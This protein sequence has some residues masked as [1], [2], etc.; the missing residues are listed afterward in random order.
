MWNEK[1][2]QERTAVSVMYTPWHEFNE[3]T[4]TYEESEVQ[5]TK[6]NLPKTITPNYKVV[7]ERTLA[8]ELAKPESEFHWVT[9][10][11]ANY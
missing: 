1:G 10:P 11:W 9:W 8:T 7:V 4:F 5:E 3:W 6:R 2:R